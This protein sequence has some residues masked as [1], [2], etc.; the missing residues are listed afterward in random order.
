VKGFIMKEFKK[1]SR[2]LLIAI[3]LVASATGA[4]AQSS[5][6]ATGTATAN[7]IRPITLAA[8]RTLAFGNV[9]PGATVGTLVIAGDSAGAQSRTGGVTQPGSQKGTVTS[10]QFDVA[11]EGSFTYTITI[12][13]AAVTIGDGGLTPDTMTVDT[14]TSDIA[15]TAGAGLLSGTAGT[16][17][18][19]TFYVGGTLNVGVN[20]APGS[21]TG[22]FSVTVAYN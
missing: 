12:P 15:T 21:Y 2:R 20:Q 1:I 17:G 9:V 6:T 8:S 10:A 22:T 14:W 11:G 5:A 16:A 7:V 13:T 3:G 4:M 18:A 19:Q